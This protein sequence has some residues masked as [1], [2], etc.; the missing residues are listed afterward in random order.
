MT[1]RRRL[2]RVPHRGA[3]AQSEQV[4][5]RRDVLVPGRR[6]VRESDGAIRSGAPTGD[7]FRGGM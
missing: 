1:S 6:Q 2:H 3:L 5:K 7:R 4:R